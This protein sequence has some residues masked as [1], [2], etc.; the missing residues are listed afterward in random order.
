MMKTICSGSLVAS[1]V[2]GVGVAGCM[3][4][5]SSESSSTGSLGAS[6]GVIIGSNCE[7]DYDCGEGGICLN[8]VPGGYCTVDCGFVEGFCGANGVCVARG[9]TEFASG[10]TIL[11]M[12]LCEPFRGGGDNCERADQS[13]F[14]VIAASSDGFQVCFPDAIVHFPQY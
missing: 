4:G 9:R 11:C 3:V 6:Q 8:D 13:C 7:S 10:P 12:S 5:G 2:L 1:F 14:G